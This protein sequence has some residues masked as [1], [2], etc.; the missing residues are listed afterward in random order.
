MSSVTFPSESQYGI[1]FIHS[2]VGDEDGPYHSGF[3][4]THGIQMNPLSQHP[5]RTPR[6]SMVHGSGYDPSVSSP[7]R[8][9]TAPDIE[10]EE[11]HV[12]D[13]PAKAR[14]TSEEVWR[15][16][17]KT[18]DGRDKAFVRCVPIIVSPRIF[19]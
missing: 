8:A 4:S 5:P 7:R 18:S 10:E 11:E 6:Q 15:E 1:S 17:F 16:I 14:V 12:H 19:V 13:H 2:T 3:E 9:S